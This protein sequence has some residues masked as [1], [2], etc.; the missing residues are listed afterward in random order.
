[1]SFSEKK[2]KDWKKNEDKGIRGVPQEALA[3]PIFM[4][5]WRNEIEAAAR[6][7]FSEGFEQGVDFGRRSVRAEFLGLLA[8]QRK[9]KPLVKNN[10][11]TRELNGYEKEARNELLGV[12]E[13]KL[14]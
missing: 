10:R 12:L 1:M 4:K 9:V 7:G 14:K 13:A 3:N 8:E 2:F 6:W 11:G 5:D